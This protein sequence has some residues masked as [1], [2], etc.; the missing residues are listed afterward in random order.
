VL[1]LV[2]NEMRWTGWPENSDSFSSRGRDFSPLH[3]QNPARFWGP[4][5]LLSSGY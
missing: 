5:I 1:C 4:H 3:S 2:I